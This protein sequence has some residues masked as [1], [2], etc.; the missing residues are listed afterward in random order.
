MQDLFNKK[1]TKAATNLSQGNNREETKK[2]DYKEES[3]NP[4]Q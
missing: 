4:T 1:E 2:A 3:N